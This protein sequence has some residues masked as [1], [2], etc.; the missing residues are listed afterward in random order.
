[1]RVWEIMSTSVAKVLKSARI[2]RAREAFRKTGARVVA[3][4]EDYARS[5][6]AG[7]L[8]RVDVIK[9]TSSKSNLTVDE[10]L[11]ESPTLKKD[12][13]LL[14][15]YTLLRETGHYALPVVS[16]GHDKTVLGTLGFRDIIKALRAA[17][18]I[19]KARAAADVMTTDSIPVISQYAPITKAWAMLVYRGMKAL[20]VV[21]SEK[22]RVP[23]GTLTPK[24]LIDSGRWYFRRESESGVTT[25]AKVRTIM[26]RGVVVARPDTPIE[27]IADYIV[28]HDF[29]LVPVIDEDGVIMGVVT[30]EDVV[31]AYLEGIKPGRIPVPVLP[32]PLPVTAAETPVYESRAALIQR[33]M[34]RAAPAPLL[35]IKAIDVAAPE[36]PAVR[37]NDTIEHA[38]NVMLRKRARIV[39]VLDE[40][41]RIVGSLS[42]RNLLYSIGIKGPLWRRRPYEKEF[43]REV[44]NPNVVI[45]REG[46][47]IENVANTMVTEDAEIALVVDKKGMLA[48][49]ITKEE[50]VR[51][52]VE[53]RGGV[54]VKNVIV[55]PGLGVVHPH[56]SLSH[57]VKKMKAYYLDA[58]AVSVGGRATGVV[59][60]NRI[61]FVPL[62]DARTGLRSRRLIWVRKLER[63]GRPMGRYVKITPLL[64]E[65]VLTPI[66][67]TVSLD[68]RISKA[69]SIISMNEV[70]GVPVEDER[71]RIIG[72][73]CMHDLVRELARAARE[74][75]RKPVETE[76]V[77]M[78]EW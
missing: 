35:G 7:F 26:K 39:L 45:V 55:P 42:T 47:P 20:V 34:V 49:V 65:D 32:P 33:V 19:P 43:I 71:G 67:A 24:D 61:P 75:E 44:M 63:G 12:E 5:K 59:S 52:L 64:V 17:G 36:I 40:K 77:R 22:E 25:V 27:S 6:Y 9:V 57:A 18:Y 4:V 14:D 13:E 15:A 41:G 28:D 53:T 37:V 1:M 51:A 78:A 10:F 69:Y 74:I 66:T 46:A 72:V 56:H 29:T 50:L 73:V 70:D 23:V 38:R 2:T 11:K 48:G 54:R 68:D 16:T 30:Q 8:T 31:R 58:L 60:E 3:V 76:E 62:E 21:R